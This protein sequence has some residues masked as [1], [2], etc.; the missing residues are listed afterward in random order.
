MLTSKLPEITVIAYSFDTSISFSS[1]IFTLISDLELPIC[2]CSPK[3]VI[4]SWCPSCNVPNIWYSEATKG[5][6]SY[7]FFSSL[8]ANFN[9]ILSLFF[10]NPALAKEK[11]VISAPAAAQIIE[12]KIVI[13]FFIFISY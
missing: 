8:I 1:N 12:N 7:S 4:T 2:V 11:Y 3:Y 13:N 6:P 5:C 10:I 9:W